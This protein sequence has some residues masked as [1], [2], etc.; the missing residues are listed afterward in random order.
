MNA[1]LII[2]FLVACT[3]SVLVA[4]LVIWAMTSPGFA[5]LLTFSVLTAPFLLFA[6]YSLI[7][8][9]NEAQFDE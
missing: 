5:I 2:V 4:A 8:S 3:V 6:F 1:K 7:R 9:F